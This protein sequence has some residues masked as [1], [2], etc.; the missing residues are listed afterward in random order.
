MFR[1]FLCYRLPIYFCILAELICSSDRLCRTL[2]GKHFILCIFFVRPPPPFKA[3]LIQ[4]SIS[5]EYN[6]LRESFVCIFHVGLPQM[7]SQTVMFGRCGPCQAKHRP[8][9][10]SLGVSFQL[11]SRTVDPCIPGILLRGTFRPFLP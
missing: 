2:Q 6:K 5:A 10:F 8:R 4:V 9:N 7:W 11:G 3:S 1:V